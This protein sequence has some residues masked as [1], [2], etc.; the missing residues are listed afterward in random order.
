M[1]IGLLRAEDERQGPSREPGCFDAPSHGNRE[2]SDEW[3]AQR[4]DA[5]KS[6]AHVWVLHG[7]DDRADDR[8]YLDRRHLFF[9][10]PA[11]D[12]PERRT[13]ERRTT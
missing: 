4:I 10:G 11:L 3:L 8:V 1:V 5:P 12:H 13:A 2:P 7:P 6:G 9:L